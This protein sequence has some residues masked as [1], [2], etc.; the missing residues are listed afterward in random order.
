MYL[1][2][3]HLHSKY[4]FDGKESID[5][6]CSAAV[7][8]GLSEIAVTDHVDIVTTENENYNRRMRLLFEDIDNTAKKY[9]GR[10]IVRKGVELGQPQACPKAYD[11]LLEANSFDFIIGSIHFLDRDEDVY[12]YDYTSMDCDKVYR[13]YMDALIAL[14]EG[15]DYD[16]LGHITYPERYMYAFARKRINLSLFMDDFERLFK[17]VLDKGRGIEINTSGF[18][19]DI[20]APFPPADVLKLYKK[21][22][23]ELITVGSDAHKAQDIGGGIAEGIRLL[24]ELDFKYIT[25]FEDRK[26]K[27]ISIV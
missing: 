23:G 21:C 7:K 1:T 22:G 25:V 24:K 11:G 3:Y 20:G 10:L 16:V 26:P 15:Y 18:R 19:Q 8:A 27:Q 14:A 6:I 5:A 9:E 13:R 17:I 2:D 4:S 12:F